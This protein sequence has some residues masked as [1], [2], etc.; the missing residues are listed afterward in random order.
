[1]PPTG[2]DGSTY[3]MLDIGKLDQT[4]VAEYLRAS[5]GSGANGA[6]GL[7]VLSCSLGAPGSPLHSG[8]SLPH[9]Q[10]LAHAGL[11]TQS[12]MSGGGVG[13]GTGGGRSP[14]AGSF[15]GGLALGRL[16]VAGSG[17]AGGGRRSGTNGPEGVGEVPGA[18][19]GGESAGGRSSSA[20]G[21]GGGSGGFKIIPVITDRRLGDGA[22][23]GSTAVHHGRA[24]SMAESDGG[25]GLQAAPRHR[26]QWRGDGPE[27]S[28]YCV[29]APES[30][31]IVPWPCK[32]ARYGVHESSPVVSWSCNLA[33]INARLCGTF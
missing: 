23:G 17:M 10:S 14:G 27:A 7:T 3:G 28:H 5:S 12:S 33:I 19:A 11:S 22:G 6:S 1:M 24:E 16:S 20:S 26:G 13:A 9:A 25:W 32:L 18:V 29:G 4:S 30:S 8:P 31:P 15:G 2:P 21:G